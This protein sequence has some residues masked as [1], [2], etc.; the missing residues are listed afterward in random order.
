MDT[1][2]ID[3]MHTTSSKGSAAKHCLQDLG[4]DLKILIWNISLSRSSCVF[5][6]PSSGSPAITIHVD[7]IFAVSSRPVVYR[8]P[9]PREASH[10]MRDSGLKEN[11]RAR[12]YL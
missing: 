11:R 5:L 7:S 1:V 12:L 2:P 6:F 9:C 10:K 8:I 3:W 4:D